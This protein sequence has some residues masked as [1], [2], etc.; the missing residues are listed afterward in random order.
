MKKALAL[1]LALVLCLGIFAGCNT[2]EPV[3]TT[4]STN[5]PDTTTEP[6][7]EATTEPAETEYTF[8]AG[9]EIEV[10][11]EHDINDL[12]MDRFVEGATGLSVKWIPRGD[13]AQVTAM[14]TQ[15]VTPSLIYSGPQY[16]H[17]MGRYGALVNLYEY[18]DIMPDFFAVFDSYGEEIK[19]DYAT[20]ED[21][22]YT[23]PA[24]LNGDT[25]R[26][27]F[28]YRDDLFEKHN[29]S[30]PTNWE[31]FLNCCKVLKE[32]YPDSYPF[33]M[34]NGVWGMIE[35]ANCFGVDMGNWHVPALDY[36]TNTYYNGWTTDYAR[37]FLK[38]V[39]EL[40][41]LGYMDVACLS[42]GT[43]DWTAAF[44]SGDSFMTQDKAFQLENIEK[45]G[46]EV[47]PNFSIYYF[48]NFPAFEGVNDLI[49]YQTRAYV[50]YGYG[51][52]IPTRCPDI[53]LACRYL[54]WM[55]SE[56]GANVLSW[57]VEGESYGV[58]ENGEKYFLEGYDFTY[59][60]RYQEA[61]YIDF[62]AS[63]AA[64]QPKT[65]EM[66]LGTMAASK[67]GGFYYGPQPVFNEEENVIFTTYIT[68]WASCIEA[69][70]QNFLLGTLDINND[71]DWA[72]FIA[73][74]KGYHEDDLLAVHNS[75]YA[76]NVLGQ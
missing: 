40:I 2:D 29:L 7:T 70:W 38:C 24:F 60:A 11:G 5:A 30:V 64:K 33:T 25:Q 56:E 12:D 47:D 28:L 76:R 8:P 34:R 36:N 44:A 61:G 9:A 71:D 17:E 1:V 31:E 63:M 13:E 75:A 10:V 48:N 6:A 55:Y 21:E 59:N 14:M 54:N 49:T 58:D 19:I 68:D 62:K 37:N 3:D 32:A 20:S 27:G 39:R 45:A 65:Q 66:I 35:F 67:E 26:Y 69:Y 41:D 73:D 42:Y 53:E 43:A 4:P 50:D 52:H 72:K 18:R 57:G 74:C 23:A 46:K 15:K 16:G 22:L 51:W